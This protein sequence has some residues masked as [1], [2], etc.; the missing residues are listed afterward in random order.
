MHSFA[1]DSVCFDSRRLNVVQTEFSPNASFNMRTFRFNVGGPATE[2]Q[3]QSVICSLH[4]NPV[5][6]ITQEQAGACSC[7]TQSE[8]EERHHLRGMYE[9]QKLGN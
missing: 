7:Y 1:G 3:Q 6:D 5:N 8:C 9:N 4:L 2:A